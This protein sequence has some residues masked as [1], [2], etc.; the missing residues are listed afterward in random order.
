M[1]VTCPS[2]QSGLNIDDKKIPPGGAR[3]KCPTCQNVFPVKPGAAVASSPS[4][5]VPLP[6]I[7]A[8]KPQRQDWEDEATRVAEV[9]LPHGATTVPV[10][11]QDEA[12]RAV[13]LPPPAIPGATMGVAP[14]SNVKM[15]SIPAAKPAAGATVPL[16]GISAAAPQRQSWEDEATRVG[17]VPLPGGAP[18]SADIDFSIDAPPTGRAPALGF[19]PGATSLEPAISLPGAAGPAPDQAATNV[20]PAFVPRSSA[21]ASI[22]LPGAG[23]APPPLPKKP[24]SSSSIPLPGGGAPAGASSIP[25]PGGGAAGGGGA[26][27]GGGVPLPGGGGGS[28]GTEVPLPGTGGDD[29]E[30]DLGGP[31]DAVALPGGGI[32]D[33]YGQ[34]PAAVAPAQD[35]GFDAPAAPAPGAFDFGSP[36]A[37]APAP[38]A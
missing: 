23:G 8:P 7:S 38:G 18:P 1:K 28:F 5:A 22:P 26:P 30:V 37:P 12:T 33:D 17:D 20:A 14:P 6:G 2:C 34:A 9:P 3:I 31:T 4:G 29:L 36:A 21:G 15:P 19:D 16:P 25:L 35:F 24:A 10:S 13:P 11:Y 32:G 27:R